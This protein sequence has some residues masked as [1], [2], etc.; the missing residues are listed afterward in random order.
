MENIPHEVLQQGGFV[1][2]RFT[3][4]FLFQNVFWRVVI[5]IVMGTRSVSA[6]DALRMMPLETKGL[7]SSRRNDLREYLKL[8]A[9]CLDYDVGYQTASRSVTGGSFLGEMIESTER[10]LTS[11]VA[12]L[13]Q[14]RP[15]AKAA[16]SSRDATEKALKA[17]LC[18]HAGLTRDEAK[19]KLGHNLSK[20]VQEVRL[21]TS[22]SSLALA[23]IDL[24]AFAPYEDRYSSNKYSREQLWR[25][26]RVAQFVAGEV[27]RSITGRNML[28]IVL[29]DPAFRDDA[30]G[31]Y[32]QPLPST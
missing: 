5:P 13:C 25:A 2:P 20:V 8:W 14:Q 6:L 7:L 16:H 29:R 11:A 15:N 1:G 26:Y 31:R 24:D 10:E 17:Y 22:S 27:L 18:H 12:D 23:Q 32:P 19:N 3:G 30:A 9:D 4:V 21:C 28:A